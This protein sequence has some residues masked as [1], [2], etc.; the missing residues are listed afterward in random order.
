MGLSRFYENPFLIK[1]DKIKYYLMWTICEINKN[2]KDRW[3]AYWETVNLNYKLK[4]ISI[5]NTDLYW[6]ILSLCLRNSQ[7]C[8]RRALT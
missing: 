4:C 8:L 6:C 7:T 2:S 5:S 1:F 3:E